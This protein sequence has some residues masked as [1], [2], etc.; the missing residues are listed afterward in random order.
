M[1]EAQT[2]LMEELKIPI[3]INKGLRRARNKKKKV[4]EDKLQ[5]YTKENVDVQAL[6][7]K[8]FHASRYKKKFCSKYVT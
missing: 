4:L 3:T 5:A 8:I 1:D 7:D 2:Y 6:R